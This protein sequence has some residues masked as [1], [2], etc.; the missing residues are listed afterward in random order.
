MVVCERHLFS[1]SKEALGADKSGEN[2]KLSLYI[3]TR[4]I[5]LLHTQNINCVTHKIQGQTYALV[6]SE[7]I[8]RAASRLSC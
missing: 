3:L 5:I 1:L 2:I 6:S 4:F 8:V 7:Y